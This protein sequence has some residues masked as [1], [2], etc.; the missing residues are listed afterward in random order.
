[1]YGRVTLFAYIYIYIYIYII[2]IKGNQV[3]AYTCMF[4]YLQNVRI[5]LWTHAYNGIV[6]N[7]YEKHMYVCN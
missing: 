1:M 4:V 3:C 7:K 2:Y 5:L 6:V